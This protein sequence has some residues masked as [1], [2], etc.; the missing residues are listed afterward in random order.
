[1]TERL[2]P[3]LEAFA[4]ELLLF[5]AG[6]DGAD[7][8]EGNVQD[9]VGGLD[10]TDDDFRWVTELVCERVGRDKCAVVSVLEGGYG[11][12]DEGRGAYDRAG[13]ARGCAAHVAALV[14]R[15]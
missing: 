11:A 1:M 14:E 12:W 5:S 3:R 6:F 2:L 4:P 13:L 15:T 9:E 8:D 10:L 7:G